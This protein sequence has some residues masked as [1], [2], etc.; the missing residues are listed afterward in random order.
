M[1]IAIDGPAGVGKGTLAKR[2]AAHFKLRHLDTGALYRAVG[3]DVLAAGADPTDANTALAA[4]RLLDATT[5]ADP[6]LRTEQVGAAASV[7]AAMPPVRAALLQFQKDFAKAPPG[8]VLDGRDIGT[9]VC[10][11]ADVKLFV[12]ASAEVRAERRWRELQAKG[13]KTPLDQILA[14]MKD[15][16]ERD[17]KRATAPLLAAADAVILD[18]SNLDVEQAFQAALKAVNDRLPKA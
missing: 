3:R 7:V 10:P 15:R 14:E 6:R 4:A 17:S 12:T 1:I 9:V 8:A 18:T 13:I 11:D 2:L 5:L 16:D